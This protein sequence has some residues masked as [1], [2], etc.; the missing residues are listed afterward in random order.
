MSAPAQ[1][2]STTSAELIRSHIAERLREQKHYGVSLSAIAEITAMTYQVPIAL[3]TLVGKTH[4]Y[5]KAAVGIDPEP[6]PVELTFC[7]HTIQSNEVLVVPDAQL[8]PR[9]RDNPFVTGE[10]HLRF[11]AGAPLLVGGL[12]VGSLC[13][14]DV[15]PR[16]LTSRE[17]EHLAYCAYTAAAILEHQRPVASGPFQL[18]GFEQW[19]AARLRAACRSG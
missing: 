11:Y 13:L 3:L 19:R 5:F 7:Q 16:T 17:S 15:R 9:F 12:R 2:Y 8:D 4:Q 6:T 10:P 14:L 18:L 1:P